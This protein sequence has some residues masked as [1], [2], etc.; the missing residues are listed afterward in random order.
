TQASEYTRS[1]YGS[2]HPLYAHSLAL[3][4]EALEL[5]SLNEIDYIKNYRKSLPVLE[6][7]W[8]ELSL[9]LARQWRRVGD[10][11]RALDYASQSF[12]RR[13][14]EYGIADPFTLESLEEMA[15]NLSELGQ[16]REAEGMLVRV[17]MA[18][19]KGF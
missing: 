1:I 17:L 6:P 14:G 18:R 7:Q 19:V 13:E 4:G 12:E 16:L 8:A 11:Q 5:L 10:Y 2:K 15:L 3:Q 9:D